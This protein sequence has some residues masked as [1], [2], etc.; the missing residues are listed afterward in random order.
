[1]HKGF[2][3]HHKPFLRDVLWLSCF[4]FGG[5]QA[6]LPIFLHRLVQKGKY[7]SETALLELQAFCQIIPGPTST[8]TLIALGYQ[9]GGIRLAYLTLLTWCLPALTLMGTAAIFINRFASFYPIAQVTRFIQPM[10]VAFMVYAALLIYRKIVTRPFARVIAVGT[11]GVVFFM[12]AAYMLPVLLLLSGSLTAYVYG[13]A[14]SH[15]PQKKS[16]RVHWHHLLLWAG[17]FIGIVLTAYLTEWELLW[18]FKDFYQNGS[19]AFG[20]GQVFVPFLFISCVEQHAYLSAADFLSGFSLMQGLPGPT[21]AFSTYVGVLAM[22]DE[23]FWMQFLGGSLAAMGIFLPGIFFVLFTYP[24]WEKL[25]NH[26]LARTTM[27]GIH[28]ATLG[29]LG[30]ASSKLFLPLASD[31]TNY[32][33]LFSSLFLLIFTRIS[34]PWIVLGGLL[35]GVVCSYTPMC[36]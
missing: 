22:R 19:I 36:N 20:G 13:S 32:L 12:Y 24:Y 7:L 11:A 29:L 3:A 33:V 26:R 35:A 8:Q 2:I 4:A 18:L 14:T 27:I 5:S 31:W 23:A 30:V 21:F 34:P 9:R 25:K 15:T 28:A 1:M 16:F 6:H 10:A 17:V